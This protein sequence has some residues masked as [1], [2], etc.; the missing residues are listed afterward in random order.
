MALTA[1]LEFGDNVIKRYSKSYLVSDSR[2]LFTC[3]HDGYTPQRAARCERVE[4]TVVAPGKADHDLIDWFSAQSQLSGRLVIGLTNEANRTD[5]D[6]QI[7]YFEGAKCFSFTEFYDY[8]VYRRRLL[9]L[10]IVAD[11]MEIDD[12][13]IQCK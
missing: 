4:V 1:V 2:L 8:D 9:K 11:K 10:A 3:S 13:T 12:V 6:A 7:L 5:S